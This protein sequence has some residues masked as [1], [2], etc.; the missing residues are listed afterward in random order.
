MIS[1]FM[2]NF[3]EGY[4]EEQSNIHY[5]ISNKVADMTAEDYYDYK[6]NQA[7]PQYGPFRRDGNY[8]KIAPENAPIVEKSNP[9]LVNVV[10]MLK[11]LQPKANVSDF[12]IR[13]ARHIKSQPRKPHNVQQ[14]RILNAD[15]DEIRYF[16]KNHRHDKAK[17]DGNATKPAISEIKADVIAEGRSSVASNVGPISKPRVD[18]I[19]FDVLPP[20]LPPFSELPPADYTYYE[21]G[22]YH[23]VHD[24]RYEKGHYPKKK[25][26]GSGGWLSFDFEDAILTALGLSHPGRSV[27][28]SVVKC[29]KIYAFQVVIRFIQSAFGG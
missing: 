9:Q 3:W 23:H 4:A 11:N 2:Y 20:G 28:P 21:G 29:S 17:D 5:R 26:R 1:G 16:S 24:L 14:F 6:S 18:R 10:E 13:L 19:G 7:Y 22:T 15:G 8:D 27:K 12:V 25:K